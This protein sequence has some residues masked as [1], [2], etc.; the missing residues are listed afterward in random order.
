MGRMRERSLHCLEMPHFVVEPWRGTSTGTWVGRMVPGPGPGTG[1]GTGCT[2][3]TAG[4]SSPDI[5]TSL[6]WGEGL[7]SQDPA[8]GLGRG[9]I[10]PGDGR[11]G[12]L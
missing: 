10:A 7:C 5:L 3:C 2:S 12:H 8:L 1:S 4:S 11:L 9:R 6:G